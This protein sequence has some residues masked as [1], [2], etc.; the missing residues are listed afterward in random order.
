MPPPS[1]S[2]MR[3]ASERWKMWHRHVQNTFHRRLGNFE[4][5]IFWGREASAPPLLPPGR[6]ILLGSQRGGLTPPPTSYS[7]IFT[8]FLKNKWNVF[9]LALAALGRVFFSFSFTPS[10]LAEP[11]IR[12]S[13]DSLPHRRSGPFPTPARVHACQPG[14]KRRTARAIFVG[15]GATGLGSR[16]LRSGARRGSTPRTSIKTGGVL[17]MGCPSVQGKEISK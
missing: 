14:D 4:E 8:F 16:D 15:S 17:F 10:R 2:S 12:E 3:H 1:S 5:I 7:V 9:N 6:A 11:E 13:Q